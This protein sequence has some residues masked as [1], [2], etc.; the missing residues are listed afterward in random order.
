MEISLSD[1]VHFLRRKESFLF[2]V[3]GFLEIGSF[4][5]PRVNVS[6]FDLS[7]FVNKDVIGSHIPYFFV[8]F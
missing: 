5:G 7:C 8:N 4:V 2:L 3:C 1:Q 6:D